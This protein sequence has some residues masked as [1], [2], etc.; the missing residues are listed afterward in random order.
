MT[1]EAKSREI[2]AELSQV[3]LDEVFEQCRAVLDPSGGATA[4][5]IEQH[6]YGPL[7]QWGD[8]REKLFWSKDSCPLPAVREKV[9]HMSEI[10]SS[11]F[12][13]RDNTVA[14]YWQP[15]VATY[16][17]AASVARPTAGRIWLVF[18]TENFDAPWQLFGVLWTADT[19]SVL[20]WQDSPA[21][22]HV[23]FLQ[24]QPQH[25][26]A[27]N[28]SEAEYYSR[29][30]VP[31]SA[32]E[33]DPQEGDN[34]DEDD[35]YDRYDAVETQVGDPDLGPQ[36]DPQTEWLATHI[37]RSVSSL[38]EVAQRHGMDRQQFL[39]VVERGL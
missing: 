15:D 8:W 29:Y 9:R 36:A 24:R 38:W 30:D 26:H 19:P 10:E 28:D 23:E 21:D 35:Y 14:K 31:S 7:A 3:F 16:Y 25:L 33:E 11:Q 20:D 13:L 37:Q 1:S 12:W 39:A 32:D 34:V 2:P 18:V 4:P 17:A 22:A 5:E 6:I 27:D